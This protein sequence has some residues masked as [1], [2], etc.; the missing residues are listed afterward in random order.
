MRRRGE[1]WTSYE[2]RQRPA[3]PAKGG[4]PSHPGGPSPR[5]RCPPLAPA[6]A[7]DVALESG[8]G[9]YLRVLGDLARRGLSAEAGQRGPWAQPSLPGRLDPHSRACSRLRTGDAGARTGHGQTCQTA[10]SA[11][12]TKSPNKTAHGWRGGARASRCA[13]RRGTSARHA[14]EWGREAGDAA[15]C[16]PALAASPRQAEDALYDMIDE[17]SE[18]GTPH[19]NAVVLS[20]APQ[21]SG[22]DLAT[23]AAPARG[24]AVSRRQAAWSRLHRD[25][26]ACVWPS[27]P[28]LSSAQAL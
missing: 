14:L 4:D 8:E 11:K 16:C 5:G 28:P 15:D 10:T 26:V 23:A 6:S 2:A 21:I 13:R 19:Y 17:G 1:A 12:A 3:G 24:H 18:P 25:V 7:Q 20:C 22:A 9:F 27:S